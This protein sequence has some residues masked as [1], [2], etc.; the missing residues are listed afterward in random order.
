M[1]N[2]LIV[3]DEP[4]I[5]ELFKLFVKS[6]GH[7]P[8]TFNNGQTAIDFLINNP[9]VNINLLLT[10]FEMAPVNGLELIDYCNKNNHNFPKILLTSHDNKNLLIQSVEKQIFRFLEKPPKIDEFREVYNSALEID[11]NTQ[12]NNDL[13]KLG[14]VYSTIVHEINNPL[15]TIML[16]TELI[17]NN[18]S[19]NEID[20]SELLQ[21]L[22]SIQNSTCRIT[23][24]I[25]DIK[26]YLNNK[27]TNI[28][29]FSVDKVLDE[30]KLG[31]KA[32][33]NISNISLD[34]TNHTNPILNMDKGQLYRILINLLSNSVD[35]I[36]DLDEKWIKILIEDIEDET[37][38]RVIDSG[39]GISEE[40]VTKLFNKNYS[41]KKATKGTGL[42]LDI[43]KKILESYKGEVK[44]EL[45]NGHTSFLIT[46]PKRNNENE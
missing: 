5:T 45:Y 30:V 25:S 26:E 7:T 22:D 24:I 2:I 38:I 1:K 19:N 40:N 42:G 8:F 9:N 11:I 13:K 15:N 33:K 20:S 31:F 3:D 4:R 43:C 17:K 6:Q 36:Y 12:K 37:L 23:N 32:I 21:Q 34:V 28:Q 14:E 16:F 35:A 41:V 46:I 27:P 10:D 18:C 44:Y 29:A 39:L